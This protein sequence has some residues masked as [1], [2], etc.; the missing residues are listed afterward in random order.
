MAP[1]RDALGELLADGGTRVAV[2]NNF[3]SAIRALVSES[4]ARDR[5]RWAPLRER[6]DQ[7]PHYP[8]AE[9]LRPLWWVNGAHR[10]DVGDVL[11]ALERLEAEHNLLPRFHR[12]VAVR[13]IS[14]E[15]YTLRVA[16]ESRQRTSAI[17]TRVG[18][19]DDVRVLLRL[20]ARHET[21]PATVEL[22]YV[23]AAEEPSGEVTIH[24]GFRT[25]AQRFQVGSKSAYEQLERA[26]DGE[27]ILDALLARRRSS[28]TRLLCISHCV[29][30]ITRR[31]QAYFAAAADWL[32]QF[33]KN[34]TRFVTPALEGTDGL[35]FYRA[36]ASEELIA[37]GK[38][39]RR[40]EKLAREIYF[41]L[42]GEHVP[43]GFPGVT[44]DDMPAL[45]QLLQR[46]IMLLGWT[47]AAHAES[48]IRG[49]ELVG[50][51]GAEQGGRQ[52]TLAV[53][54]RPDGVAAPSHIMLVQNAAGLLGDRF[55]CPHCLHA[56]RDQHD[57]ERHIETC[58]A[59][60]GTRARVAK[61]A[62]PLNSR[63]NDPVRQALLCV[64]E[65]TAAQHANLWRTDAYA[66]FDFESLMRAPTEAA[67][68]R[69]ALAE[70]VPACFCIAHATGLAGDAPVV[71]EPVV[72]VDGDPDALV[73]RFC[74]EAVAVA[75]TLVK[76]QLDRVDPLVKALVEQNPGWSGASR[77]KTKLTRV[78]RTAILIS[79]NGRGYDLPL[80]ARYGLFAKMLTALGAHWSVSCIRA[81]LKFK[82]L[83]FVFEPPEEGFVD[84]PT[85]RE[86]RFVDACEFSMCPLAS[87][88]ASWSGSGG[89]PCAGGKGSFP[90]SAWRSI[91]MLDGPVPFDDAS[92]VDELRPQSER[93]LRERI[94][95]ARAVCDEQGIAT[96]GQY[97][98]WYVQQDCLP[99]L[100]ALRG[101]SR[102]FWQLGVD[103]LACGG[104]APAVSVKLSFAMAKQARFDPAALRARA[105]AES[106]AVERALGDVL[107]RITAYRAQ[108]AAAAPPRVCDLSAADVVVVLDAADWR[109]RWCM[110]ALGADWTLD[111]IDCRVGHTRANCVASCAECNSAR[112]A[113]P[114]RLWEQRCL[115]SM[116]ERFN[117]QLCALT[118]ETTYRVLRE[119]ICGGLSNVYQRRCVVGE[120]IVNTVWRDG[121]WALEESPHR[122][123]TIT[124]LDAGSLYPFCQGQTLV[125]GELR[126]QAWPQ[127]AAAQASIMADVA[128]GAFFG[129][130]H[131]DWRTPE[132]LRTH[133]ARFP[134][135]FC[136]RELNEAVLCSPCTLDDMRANNMAPKK[137][138]KLMNVLDANELLLDSEMC[139]WYLQQGL[140]CARVRGVIRGRPVQ[141]F[142]PFVDQVAASR[143][144]ADRRSAELL[145]RIERAAEAIA[146]SGCSIDDARK[147]ARG[148]P[149]L[150]AALAEAKA[151]EDVANTLK[152]VANSAYGASLMNTLEFEQT[153][154]LTRAKFDVAVATNSLF[155]SGREHPGEL[156][157]ATFQ[158]ESS[159]VWKL[160]LAMGISVY[161][162]SKLHV[163]R[164]LY[165]FLFKFVPRERI[166]VLGGDTDCAICALATPEPV[167]V[168]PEHLAAR[169]ANG[170]GAKAGLEAV[171]VDLSR[172]ALRACVPAEKLA[173][174]DVAAEYWLSREK[175][176]ESYRR[177]G[178][179]KCEFLSRELNFLCPKVYHAVP[180]HESGSAKSS[181]KGFQRECKEALTADDYRN[182]LHDGRSAAR[183]EPRHHAARRTR[184]GAHAT[185][186]LCDE[187]RAVG[188][189]HEALGLRRPRSYGAAPRCVLRCARVFL[190]FGAR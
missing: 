156:F 186:D 171:Y 14:V 131:A 111:R 75:R 15:E 76:A 180:F 82:R 54:T 146:G 116:Y 5:A 30:F 49:V 21:S 7:L 103:P 58:K 6:I 182:V 2:D 102:A 71:G 157:E 52:L 40:Q 69:G 13:E 92:W 1:A 45:A 176:D 136:T 187:A 81:G 113:T 93:K 132:A 26:L 85:V 8:R 127:D 169:S 109:C 84:W 135:F 99:F 20:L 143:T 150:A 23:G 184:R 38:Q 160:P 62:K 114:P 24:H 170:V 110:R 95:S 66:C 153:R 168:T 19:I 32:P 163:L 80:L 183:R 27:R 133:F 53:A 10:A 43:A 56:N 174:Y 189:A 64:D 123:T 90:Y 138:R 83:S 104:G 16:V 72:V 144:A 161:N 173:E 9:R 41:R 31:L 35:C 108:D 137:G 165:D 122:V 155:R 63:E 4:L 12:D 141:L 124:H 36:L 37:E 145:A 185:H 89:L 162:R 159:A 175:C 29:V 33:I 149:E 128:S 97:L 181:C 139:Q 166:V 61:E 129:F 118:D 177:P 78:A 154:I 77:M 39:V 22:L 120:P 73:V 44:I 151:G 107:A 158:K 47:A 119:A 3:A 126:Y 164:F 190:S 125:G 117:V 25:T 91:E 115:D 55:R 28:G 34:A 74:A 18:S 148:V 17:S 48:D 65:Q 96:F 106:P 179:F 130:V 167:V 142:K 11:A 70:H 67:A 100:S 188:R 50:R 121:A 98:M 79:Y 101:F 152:L 60:H 86:L 59:L 68:A 178:A 42:H 172:A 51:F 87:F 94:A 112:A 134:P 46:P 105:A 147:R 57:L 88:L 140:V